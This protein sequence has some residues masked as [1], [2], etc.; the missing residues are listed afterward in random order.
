MPSRDEIKPQV[1]TILQSVTF[2]DELAGVETSD[3][4]DDLGL[5]PTVKTVLSVPCSKVSL[6]YTGGIEVSMTAAGDCKTVRDIIDLVFRRAGGK[7]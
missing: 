2:A 5:S 3:L 1:V 4:R 6:R 7:P